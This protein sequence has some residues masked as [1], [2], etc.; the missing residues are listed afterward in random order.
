MT[1]KRKST[2]KLSSGNRLITRK[3]FIGQ[4]TGTLAA[5]T[6]ASAIEPFNRSKARIKGL[7]LTAYSM[8]PHMKWWLGKRT[9]GELDMLGFLDYCAEQNLDGAEITSYFFPRPVPPKTIREVKR[10]A[11]MLGVDITGGAMGN[12]FAYPPGSDETKGNMRYFRTW[13]DHF[14]DLGAPVVRVFAGRKLPPGASN[15]DVWYCCFSAKGH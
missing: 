1:K 6:S 4:L 13:I 9:T 15:R 5:A 11:H 3:H 12:N 2:K 14:A 10:R 8:K 7:S